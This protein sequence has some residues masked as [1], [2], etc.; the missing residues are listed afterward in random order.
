MRRGRPALDT[1][2]R[3]SPSTTLLLCDCIATTCVYT[4]FY[5]TKSEN[6]CACGIEPRCALT[7][8]LSLPCIKLSFVMNS[9]L[10]IG[11]L[12]IHA[13]PPYLQSHACMLTAVFHCACPSIVTLCAPLHVRTL[14][15]AL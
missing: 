12:F 4:A 3:A 15:R 11:T 7:L 9:V 14:T 2:S 6:P 10:R 13:P 8:S 5:C 1:N